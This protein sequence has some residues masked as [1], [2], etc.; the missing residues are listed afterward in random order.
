MNVQRLR[1]VFHGL[2]L[3]VVLLMGHQARAATRSID[4]KER[5]HVKINAYNISG[6]GDVNGDSEMD[7]AVANQFADRHDR[8]KSGSVYVLFGPILRGSVDVHHMRG[9][10]FRIDGA[11]AGDEA[12]V[13]VAGA[14][15][16]NG[17]GLDDIVLGAWKAR[18][19][20]QDISGAAFVVFGKQSLE[21]VD[22]ADFQTGFANDQ[23]FRIDGPSFLSLTGLAVDG[24]GDVNSD[25]LGD[26]V[27]GTGL[28]SSTY[29]VFGK[30][31]GLLVDLLTFDMGTQGSQGFRIDHPESMDTAGRWAASAGDINGD[32]RGDIFITVC[33][34]SGDR[35]RMKGW[36]VHGKGSS[37][38]IDVR[39]LGRQGFRI[40][41]PESTGG[42]LADLP[43]QKPDVNRDGLGDLVIIHGTSAYVVFGKKGTGSVD[44]ASLG[45]GGYQIKGW[46]KET[47]TKS[48]L[49]SA[50]GTPDLNKDGKPEV[51]V[52]APDANFHHRAYS[53]S[54]FV[55]FGKGNTKALSLRNLR[56]H[57]YRIDGARAGHQIGWSVAGPGDVAGGPRPDVAT[58]L[59]NFPRSRVITTR[60]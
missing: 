9:A 59:H 47:N 31:D 15:D 29:V 42:S 55:V 43:G 56:A 34:P 33:G 1:G 6:L 49:S 18:N 20:R 19:L 57:G 2:V 8:S 10:G 46:T 22:L 45:R 36:V 53:G 17:D 21:N 35:C 39:D 28:G 5:A 26:V 52:G 16:V 32:G 13:S 11:H 54:V 41:R 40:R 25:G 24:L 3:L 50:T 37:S 14:G 58:D 7:F 30:D 4:L 48:L 12:G 44:P 38:S 60:P 27:I 23:G 51:L